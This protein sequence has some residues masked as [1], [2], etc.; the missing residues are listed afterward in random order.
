MKFHSHK[1]R[2]PAPGFTLVELMIALVLGL[3]IIGGVISVFI[4]NKQTYRTNEGLSR[5]QETARTAFELMAREIREAGG[6]HCGTPMVVTVLA[7]PAWW[8]DWN[9]GGLVGF[10]GAGANP[11]GVVPNPARANGTDAILIRSGTLME[12]VAID[13]HAHPVFT[14]AT[15]A[16]FRGGDILMACDYQSAAIFQATGVAYGKGKTTVAHNNKGGNCSA[17]LGVPTVCGAGVETQKTFGNGSLAILSGALW[18]I[19]DNGRGGR[20]LFRIGNGGN[21]DEVAEGVQDMQIEYLTR[22]K[23]TGN[24]ADAY[25]TADRIVAADW[26]DNENSANQVVAVRVTLTLQT[27]DKP[28]TD[29]NPLQRTMT[30]VVSLRHREIVQ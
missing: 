2:R 10:E 22:N 8:A 26:A 19:G 23:G 30:H 6:N 27:A 9:S 11:A 24:L 25:V 20:S 3:L 7:A 1:H 13:A 17:S 21:A 4:S 16:D 15:K 5:I 28:G 18:Y 14:L 12:G 29:G